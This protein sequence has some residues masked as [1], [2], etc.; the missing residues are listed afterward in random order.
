VLLSPF[1][2]YITRLEDQSIRFDDTDR[3]SHK[4]K[5]KYSRLFSCNPLHARGLTDIYT[6]RTFI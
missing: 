4:Y 5:K 3:V 6:N 2:S 1:P